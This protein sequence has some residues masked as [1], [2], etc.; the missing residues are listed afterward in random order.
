MVPRGRTATTILRLVLVL[1][2]R[3]AL[4]NEEEVG[5]TETDESGPDVNWQ[6]PTAGIV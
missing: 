1:R 6:P 2:G 4:Q 3:G 5:G